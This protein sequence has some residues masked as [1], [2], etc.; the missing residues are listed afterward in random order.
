MYL[1]N[2]MNMYIQKKLITR[3]GFEIMQSDITTEYQS[4]LK[5]VKNSGY[6]GELFLRFL[7]GFKGLTNLFTSQL[8][9]SAC[10]QVIH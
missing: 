6:L 2:Y 8:I 5:I 1:K 9:S 10:H 4:I 7:V 3:L